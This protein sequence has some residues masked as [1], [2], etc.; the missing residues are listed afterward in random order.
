MPAR[1]SSASSLLK[2]N[3]FF[4]TVGS[5][6]SSL[7]IL[8]FDSRLYTAAN[9]LSLF[10]GVF[11]LF[12]IQA[13]AGSMK[14]FVTNAQILLFYSRAF[15]LSLALLALW[16]LLFLPFR[17]NLFSVIRASVLV[18]FVETSLAFLSRYKKQYERG[19]EKEKL[20]Y[21]TAQQ[22]KLKELEVLKQQID[23]HFIFNSFN[24]L[25]YL[26][27]EDSAKARE[28]S[29]KLANV[30]RYLIFNSSK[31]LVALADEVRFAQ[32]YAYLQEIRHSNEVRI[33]FSG[34]TDAD[35]AFVVPVSIQLLIENAIKHNAFSETS[36]LHIYV[37]YNQQTL[38]V[39]N[40]IAASQQ[41]A[42]SSKIG[43]V[44]LR[45][46]CSLILGKEPVIEKSDTQF[47]VFLPV[48]KQ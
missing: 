3:I 34:F 2:E 39:E 29:N 4:L 6:A 19:Q 25:S 30:Y 20:I 37:Q 16:Y 47:R 28:F 48:L 45:D 18:T 13:F 43:L 10:L 41:A 38:L 7:C 40:E 27:E 15:A 21:Q 9:V 12:L 5:F 11:V 46:R 8:A 14:D 33:L 24:T 26:I 44:N 31:N 22:Q 23:P 32:D 42:A 17:F 36:P 35:R 1:P